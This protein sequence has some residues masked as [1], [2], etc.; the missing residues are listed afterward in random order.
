MADVSS[1]L[2]VQMDYACLYYALHLFYKRLASNRAF[3]KRYSTL[4]GANSVTMGDLQNEADRYYQEFLDARE[5]FTPLPAA[6]Y[7]NT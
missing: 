6:L 5:D 3:Y 4:V 7:H 1:E 2:N